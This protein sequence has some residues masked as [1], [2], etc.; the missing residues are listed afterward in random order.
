MFEGLKDIKR[1]NLIDIVEGCTDEARTGSAAELLA[2]KKDDFDEFLKRLD[3]ILN[4]ILYKAAV[5]V[6]GAKQSSV[7]GIN[8]L[9][10]ATQNANKIGILE[11]DSPVYSVL[12][13]ELI[14]RRVLRYYYDNFD[15][16]DMISYPILYATSVGEEVD[17][18]DVYR[19]SPEDAVR[20]IT[21]PNRRRRKLAGTSLGN[22]GAFFDERF[23]VNDILWGRLDCAERIA[24]LRCC[25]ARWKNVA[26][27]HQECGYRNYDCSFARW[28]RVC[29]LLSFL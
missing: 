21:A 18:V 6:E 19:I 27:A 26:H 5:R 12:T 13:P 8:P 2:T 3:A 16:Y 15:R 23:R 10:H 4:G 20:L 24:R 17:V 1:T 25:D 9:T 29:Q 7:V 28:Y 14:A 11:D 22:F